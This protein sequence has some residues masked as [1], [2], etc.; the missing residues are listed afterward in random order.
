MPPPPVKC[1]YRK[2]SRSIAKKIKGIAKKSMAEAATE[3]RNAQGASGDEVV[4]C[5]VSCDGT[6]QR[7][8]FSSLNGCIAV[9]SI[10]SG[11]VL[12]AEALTK[13]CKQC[14]LHF[15]MHK[16]SEEYRSWKADHVNCK[17]NFDGSA[18]AMEAEGA[19]RIFERSIENNQLRYTELYGDGDSKSH[20]Q[21]KDIYSTDV[22]EVQK[23]ARHWA[24][25]KE[26]WN[27]FAEAKKRGFQTRWQGKVDESYDRQT[28][29]LLWDCHQI[30]C[31][32]S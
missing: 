21:V 5:G 17:A 31:W 7:R 19:Q 2:A 22:L 9:L 3:I 28:S 23:K 15:H 20:Q 30:K 26:S 18:P 29:E 6:W 10:E 25:P 27:C 13:V 12:D 16:E 24:G 8:G 1:A 11:K 32:Q 14:Q 4:N